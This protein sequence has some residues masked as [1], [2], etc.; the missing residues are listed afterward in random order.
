MTVAAVVLAAGGGSRFDGDRHKLLASLDGRPVIAWALESALEA[1]FNEVIVVDGAVDL[2][3]IVADL[4]FGNGASPTLLHNARWQEGQAGSL[5]MAVNHAKERGHDAVVV[6]LGDQPLV[7]ISAWRTVGATRGAIVAARFDEG[8][9]PPVKLEESV[10]GLLPTEGDDGARTLMES[11]PHMVAEVRCAGDG[12][13]IDT[14]EDLAIAAQR[15]DDAPSVEPKLRSTMPP[16]PTDDAMVEALLG[17]APMGEYAVVVR[18]DD[19]SPVVLSNAPLL[20]DGTPM[21]TRFWLCDP[22]LVK[23]ISHIESNGGVRRAESQIDPEQI[24]RTHALAEAERNGHIASNH[25]GPRPF[26][27]VGGTRKG[28]KCLHTHFANYLAGA[29]DAIG[30]WTERELVAE[31]T[32]FDPSTPGVASQ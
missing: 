7:G 23:S 4:A 20:F 17:R 12:R 14:A 27:G 28:V 9:R 29:P 1:G 8:R 24:A 10:W 31:G 13:D 30:A 26:G 22:V 32:P 25:T 15:P 11:H 5:Q 6:G 16:D 2:T 19:R 21:P 3:D 18:R